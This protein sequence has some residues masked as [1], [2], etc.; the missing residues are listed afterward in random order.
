MRDVY[1]SCTE[2]NRMHPNMV[3]VQELLT[4]H[5]SSIRSKP[6]RGRVE[7]KP[8]SQTC[9]RGFLLPLFFSRGEKFPGT[10]N[11][12]LFPSRAMNPSGTRWSTGSNRH[13]TCS[14]SHTNTI[15][16]Y[17]SSNSIRPTR[18]NRDSSRLAIP[19]YW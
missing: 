7:A 3:C 16:G 17:S 4:K 9:P 13:P 12:F 2:Y 10:G 18:M 19:I 1:L 5:P 6:K 11:R 14:T 15:L 8:F